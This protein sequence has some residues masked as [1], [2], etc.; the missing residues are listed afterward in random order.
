M[1]FSKLSE[2]LNRYADQAINATRSTRVI[3]R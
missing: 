3:T 2:G 1:A